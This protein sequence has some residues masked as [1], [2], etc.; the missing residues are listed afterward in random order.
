MQ[1]KNRE[2]REERWIMPNFP[3]PTAFDRVKIS[4]VS[5]VLVEARCVLKAR[6]LIFIGILAAR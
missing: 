4:N 6:A 2:V 1:E 5:L 3:L